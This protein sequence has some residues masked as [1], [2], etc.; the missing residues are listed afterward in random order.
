MT[1]DKRL[2]VY[3]ISGIR[4]NLIKEYEFEGLINFDVFDGEYLVLYSGKNKIEIYEIEMYLHIS[5][6]MVLPY[7][8]TYENF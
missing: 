7:Y 4:I 3:Q 8:K 1:I 6:R 2:C 5:Y